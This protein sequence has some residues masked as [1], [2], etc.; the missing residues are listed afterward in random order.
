MAKPIIYA[1]NIEITYNLGKSNEFKANN[2]TTVEIFPHEYIILFGPSGCGKSTLLYSMFGVLRPSKGKMWVKGE[3][4]YD[5][6]SDEMVQYQ[7]KIMGIMYQ[8]FNLIPSISVM[9]NVAL[10]LIFAGVGAKEREEKAMELCKRFMIDKVANKR[11]P[12]LSG[13]QQQ[14]VSVARSLVNDPEILIA[15]EPV[16][17]LDSITAAQV[18][19]TLAEINSKDKKTVILVTHDAKYLPYAHR[20][21]YMAD[22]KIVRVVPNPEKR[23]IV[24]PP[25]GSTIITEIEQLSRIYPYDSPAELQVKSVINFITQDITYDQIQR[26]EKMTEQVINGRMNQDA[27][28][29]LLMMEYSKGGAGIDVSQ[30]SRMSERVDKVLSHARDVARFRRMVGGVTAIPKT[31]YVERIEQFLIDE[32]QLTLSS[33]QRKHLNEAIEYRIGGYTKKDDFFNQLIMSVDEGGVGLSFKQTSDAS[34][35]LEKMIAQGVMHIGSE[36]H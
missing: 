12:L 6:T 19:D 7:R 30:A 21:V 29:R 15:D 11:P 35:L 27:Y 34:R 4:I 24:L 32:N 16:G 2:G 3:S 23:Q 31:Q 18:M 1:D 17:N 20:V 9:D 13:G 22:G 10:P 8:Q 33:E 36:H 26:L 25:P 28:L 14:R 5:Y